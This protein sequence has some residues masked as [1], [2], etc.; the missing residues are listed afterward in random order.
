VVLCVSRAVVDLRERC[1]VASRDASRRARH[2]LPPRSCF[3]NSTKALSCAPSLS[4]IVLLN[5]CRLWNL[6]HDLEV[7]PA[8]GLKR[9][10]AHVPWRQQVVGARLRSA[11]QA[12]VPWRRTLASSCGS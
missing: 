4:Y 11:R 5:A 3:T 12:L 8:R 6:A 9:R 10:G 7:A 1:P 2:S